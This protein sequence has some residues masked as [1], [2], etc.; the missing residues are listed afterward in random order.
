MLMFEYIV[1]F[2]FLTLFETF[3][4]LFVFFLSWL[5]KVKEINS[6]LSVGDISCNLGNENMSHWSTLNL[7]TKVSEFNNFYRKHYLK[8]F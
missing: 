6:I 4:S 3:V 5:R 7:L 2:I 1:E 8:L